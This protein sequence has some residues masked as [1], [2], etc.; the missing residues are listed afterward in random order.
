M[1][2]HNDPLMRKDWIDWSRGILMFLVYVYHSEVYYGDGHSWSWT[3]APFFLTGFFFISGYLF[4]KDLY[5]VSLSKKCKQILKGLLIPYL[6][7]TILFIVPKFLFYQSDVQQLIIDVFMFRAS[8]FVVVIGI[9]QLIYAI[10]LYKSPSNK[11]LFFTTFVLFLIGYLSVYLY[12][13]I[14]TFI[15]NSSW[16]QSPLLPNRFPFCLNIAFVMCPFF[17]LGIVYRQIKRGI[18]ISVKALIIMIAVYTIIISVDRLYI[19]SNITIAMHEYINLPI[20]F[21]YGLLGIVILIEVS[22]RIYKARFINYIGKHSILFYFLNGIALQFVT[23]AANIISIGNRGGYL[24]IIFIATI[25][26]L[27]T[28]PVVWFITRY[29]PFLEGR[30]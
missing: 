24:S 18:K 17:Y 4:C 28:F 12:Q 6:F 23:K 27:L 15:A 21:L 7:F 1:N 10:T 8:W 19:G 25:A 30:K 3:F 29:F 11:K 9:L 26:C 2:G 13:D 22:K 5:A 16:L 14:P 20:V